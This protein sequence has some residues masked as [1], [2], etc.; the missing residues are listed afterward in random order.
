MEMYTKERCQ[1]PEAK[2]TTLK[3]K[4]EIKQI[5]VVYFNAALSLVDRQLNRKY[6][7]I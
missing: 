1:I 2:L 4:W 5:R 6:T 3:R 7:G